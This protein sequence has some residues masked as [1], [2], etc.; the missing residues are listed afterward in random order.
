LTVEEEKKLICEG[1]RL[2]TL[3]HTIFLILRI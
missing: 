3:E 2:M 1:H